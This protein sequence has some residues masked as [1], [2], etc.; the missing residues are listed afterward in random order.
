MG[1]LEREVVLLVGSTVN[2]PPSRRCPRNTVD[3]FLQQ[4]FSYSKS[5]NRCVLC[6]KGFGSCEVYGLTSPQVPHR[7][8]QFSRL[9][10]LLDSRF[11][12]F[13]LSHRRPKLMMFGFETL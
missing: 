12:V 1:L 10:V 6:M 3:R 7:G 8:S 2:S 11:T 4:K 5:K 13:F 9:R